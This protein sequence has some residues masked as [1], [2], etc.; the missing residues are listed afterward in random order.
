MSCIT[1]R[2]EDRSYQSS[3]EKVSGIGIAGNL[4]LAGFKLVAGIVGHSRAM[5][6]D[7]LHSASDIAGGIIVVIGV[8]ISEKKEDRDHPYGHERLESIASILLAVILLVAGLAMGSSSVETLV[9]GSYRD[10]PV[11]GGIALAAAIVSILVKESM[12]WMTLRRAKALNS[13]VLQAE[14]LHHR[15]DSLS[16]IGSL[17]GIAGAR[18]GIRSMDAAAG[19]VICAFILKS[20]YD[21]FR[22]AMEKLIDHRSSDE[23]EERIRNCV[24]SFKEVKRIDLLRTREFGRKVYVD[25]EISMD[26]SLTLE[27]AHSTAERIHDAL[28]EQFPEIKHVM[29]HMNPV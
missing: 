8:R 23:M 28:E 7:A 5:I 1:K 2:P 17:A 16:S 11:P 18:M 22:E 24:S 21:I 9:S 20:A 15:S 19:L 12:Y 4:L 14:A 3:V 13:E 26:G 29:I 10:A 27:E 6:S 25:L